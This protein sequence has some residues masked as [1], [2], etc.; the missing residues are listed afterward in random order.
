MSLYC[1]CF[2]RHL[3]TPSYPRG[4]PRTTI[5]GGHPEATDCGAAITLMRLVQIQKERDLVADASLEA[6]ERYRAEGW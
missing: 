4:Q 3:P 2:A 1:V 5:R 6:M